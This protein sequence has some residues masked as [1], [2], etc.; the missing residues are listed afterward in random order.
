MIL[1]TG[2]TGHSG[3]FFLKRLIAENYTGKIRAIVRENSNTKLID[4]SGLN[5]EKVV[6]D[7]TD[8][9]FLETAMQ[10]V[11]TVIHITAIHFSKGLVDVAIKCGVKWA[12]LV[13]TTG[14][15]SKYKSA[16]EG[17]IAIE[18]GILAKRAQI[19]VT[20]L[21][22]TM[23]YGSSR[24]QNM[25]KLVDYLYRH[26]FFPLFG[27]GRNLMQPVHAKDLGNA[28][29]G[30]LMNPEIT[31]NNNYNLSGK[32]PITYGD[33]V[34]HVVKEL[35]T[36]CKIVQF[37]IWMSVW[38]ARAY[39]LLFRNALISVEQV[40]RMQEDKVFSHEKAARDF[41]YDPVSFQEGIKG[42]VAEYL[43]STAEFHKLATEGE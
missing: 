37:P 22:P 42:E 41:G 31:I 26:R 27:K 32:E 6:G 4:D 43:Q 5:I 11:E 13:H 8:L 35:G 14:R 39:N 1:V 40:L 19:G 10:E 15:Y 2:I 36:K 3:S 30:V 38:G 20:V 28:Y 24:D 7:I 23:I 29:Y 17:Y 33:L 16:S 34:R 21:R 25:Y 12:I 9:A 18:D